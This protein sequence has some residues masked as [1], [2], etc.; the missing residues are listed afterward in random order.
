MDANTDTSD[1][2]TVEKTFTDARR[3][4]RL[5]GVMIITEVLPST[6]RNAIWYTKLNQRLCDKY[7]S[8]FPSMKQY[9]EMLNQRFKCVS[10]Y[11]ILGI[12]NREGYTN[13][14]GPLHSDWRKV[15]GISFFAMAKEEEIRS[16]EGQV[17]R[18]IAE[19]KMVQFIKD[20]DKTSEIGYL[21][22]LVCI[23]M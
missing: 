10:K 13:P 17:R 4:L 16:M 14:E 15:N 6:I 8:M 3:V 2:P 21:T 11:S 19:E 7:C 22:V 18:M 20:H 5:D 9:F 1:F 12:R 23:V